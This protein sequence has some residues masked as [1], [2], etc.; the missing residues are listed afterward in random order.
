M[1]VINNLTKPFFWGA[2]LS[3]LIIHSSCNNNNTKVSNSQNDTAKVLSI[4]I[5]STFKLPRLADI[6]LLYKNNPFGDRVI[7]RSNIR[8]NLNLP[9][10]YKF[11]FLTRDS[12]CKLAEQYKDSTGFPN[13]LEF[14]VFKKSDSTYEASIMNLRIENRSNCLIAIN[15]GCFKYMTFTK[16]ESILI[17]RI[18][19]TIYDK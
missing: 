18:E 3:I 12:I 5:D 11:K 9:I 8:L 7:V 1:T 13:Y 19:K 6:H 14:E 16:R 2:F 17:P 10:A 4:L 15:D